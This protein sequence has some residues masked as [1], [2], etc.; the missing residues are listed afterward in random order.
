ME[1]SENFSLKLVS[2]SHFPLSINFPLSLTD[3]SISSLLPCQ[4]RLF[5]LSREKKEP[6][7]NLEKII[8]FSPLSAA[9]C[10]SSHSWPHV[11]TRSSPP[12]PPLHDYWNE[13]RV[14]NYNICKS[15]CCFALET[16]EN[17]SLALVHEVLNLFQCFHMLHVKWK[18]ASRK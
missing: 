12:A 7:G 11:A 15:C 5:V 4:S 2:P 13:S 3:R 18:T 1:I 6:R 9:A 17:L 8:F 14:K 16:R 10:S